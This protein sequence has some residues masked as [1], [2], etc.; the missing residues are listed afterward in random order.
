M[1]LEINR[2]GNNIILRGLENF[3]LESILE[4]GQCFRWD[5]NKENDYTGI[6]RDKIVRIVQSNSSVVFYN[7]SQQDFENL[8][9]KYFDM[10][11]DYRS[12]IDSIS[13]NDPIM[14]IASDFAPGI[15]ILRQPLFE[16]LITFI[17]SA[18]NSIPNIRRVV[19]RLSEMYG[20]SLHY[21]GKELYSFP[22][23]DVLADAPLEKI[24]MS[25]AGFRSRYIKKT[26]VEFAN[27]PLTVE[28]LKNLGYA[29][30]KDALMKYNGVGTKVADCT[31]LFSGAFTNAFPVDVWVKKI[32]EE[33][34]LKKDMPL[35]EISEYAD[36]KFGEMGGYAQ[37]YLF[38][39]AR[40][41][42]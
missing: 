24:S 11:T 25:K 19:A 41:N 10:G 27:N 14:K 15:R 16:T 34:Y 30:A 17:I 32:M 8:W 21:E 29:K 22:E 38:Y 18:N 36:K 28:N 42:M 6:V 40:S 7:C 39:Y 5:K 20:D 13:I 35:K 9:Y 23:P 12:I 3:D 4:C 1:A 26:A 2:Q 31:L 37:Q 33:L